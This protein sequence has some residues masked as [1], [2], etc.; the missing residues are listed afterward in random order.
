M[1]YV[2][3]MGLILGWLAT[4][5]L[6]EGYESLSAAVQ[7][8][9]NLSSGEKS[10]DDIASMALA[11]GLDAV[12]FTDPDVRRVSYGVPF[13][14]NLLPF[15][16]EREGLFAGE[17]VGKFLSQIVRASEANPQLVL[18]DGVESRPFYYW[19]T[20]GDGS[21]PLHQWDKRLAAVGLGD[22]DAYRELPV[23]GGRGLWGW[24]GLSLLMLWPLCGL[25][26][27]LIARSHWLVLRIAIGI[28]SLLCMVNN[29]PYK[30]PLWDSYKGDLGPAPY[31]H[32]IDYVGTRGGLVLW[33]PIDTRVYEE[34]IGLGGGRIAVNIP[35]SGALDELLK[36]Y[37]YT[38]FAA[39]HTGRA[40]EVEP[41]HQWDKI[42][43]QYLHGSRQRPVWAFGSADCEGG[44]G[45]DQ[46]LTV[47]SVRERSR[48]GLFEALQRGR[49]Y[50]VQGGGLRLSLQDFVARSAEKQAVAGEML[51]SRGS[52]E[53]SARIGTA[54]G[55]AAQVRVRLV[56][57]GKVVEQF[58]GTTPLAI[59]HVDA[60][61]AAG[62]KAY[63]R[64]LVQSADSKL[65]SNPIFAKGVIP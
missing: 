8:R 7:V 44:D 14:R 63:Y 60:D 18:I 35:P 46:V 37:D 38:A 42:L 20:F 50:A 12:V 54:S 59:R 53:I 55:A 33:L 25:A 62:Q 32:Y 5:A 39:L 13:L 9:T 24:R 29:A 27:A 26:Y 58:Q 61:L 49:M 31:Q 16:Y 1:R 2:F 23:S 22:A 28:V 15:S 57:S 36:T 41:G 3:Y 45:L 64:L 30:V 17:A 51:E 43:V 52:V 6:A 11:K 56:R 40:T 65:V 47:F 34:E 21:W 19:G 4:G 10:V 48:S